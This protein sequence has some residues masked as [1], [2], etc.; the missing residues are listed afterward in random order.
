VVIFKTLMFSY[1]VHQKGYTLLLNTC[2][3]CYTSY[4]CCSLYTCYCCFI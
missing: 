4:I 2:Y 3:I 1:T